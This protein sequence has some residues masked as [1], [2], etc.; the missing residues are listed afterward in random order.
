MPFQF[1][2]PISLVFPHWTVHFNSTIKYAF[3]FIY[4]Y[5]QPLWSLFILI[6]G[7]FP[8]SLLFSLFKYPVLY[9]FLIWVF[10][11]VTKVI[12]LFISWSTPLKKINKKF[13]WD[14]FLLF[15]VNYKFY[16]VF[17]LCFFLN[18]FLKTI[19]RIS[20]LYLQL[21]RL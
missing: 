5:S 7:M 9:Q 15:L 11:V 20:A 10:P 18:E 6:Q 19:N 8:S 14:I 4:L 13:R 1:E 2:E 16:S 17:Y 3:V 21:N 12:L